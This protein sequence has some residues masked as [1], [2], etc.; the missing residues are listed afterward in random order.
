MDSTDFHLKG[1]L[2]N[3]MKFSL[4]L[5]LIYFISFTPETFSQEKKLM[6][7]FILF[8]S[9]TDTVY[10]YYYHY[11]ENNE[12]NRI[13]EH[14][15]NLTWSY[16]Y[17]NDSLIHSA[18]TSGGD[19]SYTTYEYFT[20]SIIGLNISINGDTIREIYLFDDENKIVSQTDGYTN[21]SYIW[22]NENCTVYT[23]NSSIFT[24]YYQSF[25]NPFYEENKNF[26]LGTKGSLNYNEFTYYGGYVYENR[27]IESIENYPTIVERYENDQ[28]LFMLYFNYLDFTGINE[29]YEKK[30]QVFSVDYYDIMGRKIDKPKSGFYI[31]KQTTNDGIKSSK[32]YIVN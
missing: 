5:S 14:Y 27:V 23:R 31:K 7:H 13:D 22:E 24:Y 25:V 26:R 4:L 3:N 12:L 2:R 20:D 16:F 19:T 28:L 15:N 29:F 9:L 18:F 21:H 30:P 8:P 6:N 32:Y 11:N 17:N 10:K 1:F